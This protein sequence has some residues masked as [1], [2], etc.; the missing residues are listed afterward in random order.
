M[1]LAHHDYK[2]AVD[3]TVEYPDEMI[4]PLVKYLIRTRRWEWDPTKMLRMVDR[5]KTEMF[6]YRGKLHKI[7]VDRLQ[8]EGEIHDYVDQQI[9][10]VLGGLVAQETE[11]N[12]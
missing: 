11:D 4:E 9:T 7:A 2:A 10:G 5:L 6:R 1:K 3:I 12:G 8:F